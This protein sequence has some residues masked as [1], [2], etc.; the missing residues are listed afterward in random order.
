MTLNKYAQE[1]FDYLVKKLPDTNQAT[2]LEITE[3]VTMKSQNLADDKI[4]ENNQTW[5]KALETHD[6]RWDQ[7]LEKICK[8]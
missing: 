2:L 6:R 4:S 1:V 3:F 8:Y 5:Q 7:F